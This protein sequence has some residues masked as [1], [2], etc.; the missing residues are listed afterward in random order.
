ME[1]EAELPFA[2]L[3]DLV[4]PVVELLGQ[5]PGPQR[6]ALSGALALG[7]P[8]PGDRFAVAAATLSLLAAAAERAPLVALID[9]AHWL[10][11]P[12]RE[13][14]LFAARR[15][16][17]EGVVLL[18]G[19]RERE[20]TH[21]AGVDELGLLGLSPNDAAALVDR[22]GVPVAAT[23]RDQV[24]GQTAG[25]PLAILETVAE[26]T[27]AERT[28]TVPIAGPLAGGAGLQRA[29]MQ[30]IGRLSAETCRALLIAATSETG[31]VAE[32]TRALAAVGLD[33]AAL[34]PAQR[35]GLIVIAENH[36]SFRHPLVRSAAYHLDRGLPQRAAHRALAGA[37]PDETD[38]RAAWHLAAATTGPSEQ[39]MMK[40]EDAAETALARTAYSVAARTYDAAAR[41]TVMELTGSDS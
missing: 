14:L 40:L 5:I 13:A 11:R 7:P 23:V 2:G 19:M 3:A 12:S 15:V 35:D 37:I 27:A 28:G 4:R 26:L 10:D 31:A 24:V 8:V 36:V 17:R 25:N 20:W 1:A 21:S 33:V 9:D 16:R 34:A 6:A 30:R 41:F 22:I 39:V 32:I 38:G 29:F 18:L